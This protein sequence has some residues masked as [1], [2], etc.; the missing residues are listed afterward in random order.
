M[1]KIQLSVLFVVFL[2]TVVSCKKE[3]LPVAHGSRLKTVVSKWY[4]SLAYTYF[5]YDIQNRLTNVIDSNNNGHKH[6]LRIDYDAQNRPIKLTTTSTYNNLPFYPDQSCSLIYDSNGRIVKKVDDSPVSYVN[7]TRNTYTYDAKGRLIADTIHSYWANEIFSYT[8][9]TYDNNDNVVETKMFEKSSGVIQMVETAIS[10]YDSK[11][12]PYKDLGVF[13]YI[14]NQNDLYLNKNN[15][16]SENYQSGTK[17]NFDY[18]YYSNG[19][20]RR[21]STKDN[22]DPSITY[23]D[24]FYE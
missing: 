19:L 10:T 15:R 17:V 7:V 22:S 2:C 20:P 24:F 11:T 3:G 12:N 8:T 6:N 21:V 18:Q 9:Y 14:I 4:D 23:I 13:M 1:Y 5:I 16:N